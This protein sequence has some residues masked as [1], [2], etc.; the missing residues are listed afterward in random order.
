MNHAAILISLILALPSVA[1]RDV[2]E[3]AAW[4]ALNAA[5]PSNT[6]EANGRITRD[7]RRSDAEVLKAIDEALPKTRG[8]SAEPVALYYR[9]SFLF[10]ADRFQDA[11]D[12]YEDMKKRFPDHGLCKSAPKH[13]SLVDDAIEDCRSEIAIR[14]KHKIIRLPHAV[15]DDKIKAIFHTS[16]G[17][18]EAQFY[19]NVAPKTVAN[20]KKVIEDGLYN[21]TYFHRVWSFRRIVGGSPNTKNRDRRDDDQ[22]TMSYDL[23]LE[24]SDAL[25]TA[26]A[27]SMTGLGNGRASGC[28]FTICVHDQPQLNNTSAVFGRVTKGLEIVRLISQ[29]RTDDDNNPYDHVMLRSVEWIE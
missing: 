13:P 19:T 29:Q 24:L 10:R 9:G 18:F 5:I 27:I 22:G 26:G 16:L 2:N 12:V 6:F 20:F 17:D 15:L 8:T 3:A 11:L 4:K 28:M 1:Q 7:T 14:A 25:Q 21:G 23:P